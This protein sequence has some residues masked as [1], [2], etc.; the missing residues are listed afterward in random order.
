MSILSDFLR[1]GMP[2]PRS[3]LDFA[4]QAAVLE[5][6]ESLPCIAEVLL[7]CR[8]Q[9][10]RQQVD[11]SQR[12]LREQLPQWQRAWALSRPRFHGS[13]EIS[14]LIERWARDEQWY[15]LL[16]G[17]WLEFDLAGVDAAPAV[18]FDIDRSDYDQPER[19]IAWMSQCANLLGIAADVKV[20]LFEALRCSALPACSAQPSYIGLMLSRQPASLRVQFSG[21]RPNQVLALLESVPYLYPVNA[22]DKAVSL[23]MNF[24]D[25]VVLCVD[26]APTLQARVGL[27]AFSASLV[28]GARLAD[29]IVAL[30]DASLCTR[31][32]KAELLALPYYASPSLENLNW[33]EDFV[34]ES[35]LGPEEEVMQIDCRLNHLKL[36]CNPD[37]PLEAKAYLAVSNQHLVTGSDLAASA[38][39]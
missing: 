23:L 28:P 36:V 15:R 38:S 34:L 9:S 27:E 16:K 32:K 35:L 5:A 39:M 2:A 17:I 1:L 22:I 11:L 10:K 21:L 3:L 29:M 7:E 14:N 6:S 19:V 8:L 26:F 12:L 30:E 20:A 31:E 37:K 33:P 25:R 24:Y 4:A 18:F 13:E